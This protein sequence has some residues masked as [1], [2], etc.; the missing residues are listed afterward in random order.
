MTD[1][2]DEISGRLPLLAPDA[3]SGDQRRVY[4]AVAGGPRAE[5]SSFGVMDQ[6]GRLLGPYNAMLH[7]PCVGMPLQD[8]GAAVRFRTGFSPREREIAILIVAAYWKSDYIWYAHA[9][10]GHDVGLSDAELGKLQVGDDPL[11][12]DSR[13]QVVYKVM[14]NLIRT[15]DLS[16]GMY[17]DSVAELGHATLVDLITLMGYYI[18]L[19]QLLRV[20]KVGVPTDEAPPSWELFSS[21]ARADIAC[22][23]GEA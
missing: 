1:V 5:Q 6:L 10:T 4:E 12:E 23:S 11:F 19:A 20:F 22:V 14:A 21:E 3:L 8:L 9:R 2:T 7:S 16:D 18:T 17:A 15:G 13:E